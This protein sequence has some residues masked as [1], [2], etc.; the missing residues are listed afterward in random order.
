MKEKK[1]KVFKKI[2]SGISILLLLIIG[3]LI[4]L[5]FIFKD[6]IVKMVKEEAN[7][8]VNAKIDFGN[9]NLSLIK[10]FPNFYFSIEEIKI[11]G[12]AEFEGVQ[13]ATIKEIDLVVDVMSVINGESISIKRISIVEPI[14]NTLVLANG[15]ANYDIAKADST[16][17]EQVEDT[18]SSVP[19]KMELQQFEIVDAII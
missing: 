5:P 11:G 15:K 12:L 17:D 10:S 19:F 14:I 16:A 4:A 1:N 7:K 3:T 2:F 13:L 8:S 9:F 18:T 6:D